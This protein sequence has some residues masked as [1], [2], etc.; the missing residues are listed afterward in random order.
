MGGIVNNPSYGQV[1][2]RQE[3]NRR[4]A[5]LSAVCDV[6]ICGG[7]CRADVEVDVDAERWVLTG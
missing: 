7:V 1:G 5:D 2:H 6:G 4:P 3:N